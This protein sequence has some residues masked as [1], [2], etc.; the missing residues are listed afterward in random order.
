MCSFSTFLGLD[1]SVDT[2]NRIQSG[3][4]A[5][6][7]Y[8]D[9]LFIASYD[10]EG[11][12]SGE[13]LDTQNTRLVLDFENADLYVRGD[14]ALA[15]ALAARVTSVEVTVSISVRD[16]G[17]EVLWRIDHGQTFGPYNWHTEV[18]QT[19][20]LESGRHTM[21]TIDLANDGWHGGFWE[22]RVGDTVIAGPDEVYGSGSSIEFTIDIPQPCSTIR[23]AELPHVASGL[24]LGTGPGETCPYTCE[25]GYMPVFGS[26]STVKCD[27]GSWNVGTAACGLP[28]GSPNED[29]VLNI[30]PSLCAG[31]QSGGPCSFTCATGYYKHEHA[32]PNIYCDMDGS[33]NVV[34]VATLSFM[35]ACF[36]P[37][38]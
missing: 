24:C 10:S 20:T 26:A 33:W 2:Q 19:M 7:P 28:C 16:W 15:G 38:C 11:V 3:G 34:R 31:T 1:N 14:V 6:D 9:Q 13:A 27:G 21:H 25:E 32:I 35:C 5:T 23:A 12:M 36:L 37:R 30:A 29:D 8:I 4:R 22:I 18:Q 17:N